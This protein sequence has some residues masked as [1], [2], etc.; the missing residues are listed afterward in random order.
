MEKTKSASSSATKVRNLAANLGL[1]WFAGLVVVAVVTLRVVNR[2]V[3]RHVLVALYGQGPVEAGLRIVDHKHGRLSNGGE[4]PGFAQFVIVATSFVVVAFFAFCGS[5]L[6]EWLNYA[7]EVGQTAKVRRRRRGTD[8][9]TGAPSLAESLTQA[10]FRD[11]LR[12]GPPRFDVDHVMR[13]EDGGSS[14]HTAIFGYLAEGSMAPG[15][16]LALR[17][18]DGSIVNT[19]VIAMEAS[20]GPVAEVTAGPRLLAVIVEGRHLNLAVTKADDPGGGS[21][22]V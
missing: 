16:C 10:A 3:I 2:W 7:H 17:T 20:D 18:T 1:L 15:T 22:Q 5:L 6:V 12:P 11:A 9:V 21:G 4:L 19:H 13:S 8:A 14:G